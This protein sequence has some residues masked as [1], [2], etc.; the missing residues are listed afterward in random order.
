M[1]S[2]IEIAQE[3]KLIRIDDLA[4]SASLSDDEFEPYG[5]DKAKVCLH[6]DR[7]PHGKLILVTATSGMPAGSG[8]T[9]TSI[10]L[11]QG[12]KR[13][14]EKAVV[15]LREPSLGPCFGMKGGAAGGGYSQVL[16]MESINLHFTGD[17]HAITATNNLLA[18]MI[19]N[20]RHQRQVDLK[21]VIW[22]RVLDVNDRMLRNIITGLGGPANGIPT[23]TGFDITVASELMAVLCLANDLDDLRARIDRLVIGIKRDGSAYT[24]KELGATGALMALLLE[25]MKPNLVQTIE[26]NLAFVHGGPFANIAH[27]CNSVVA[28]KAALTLGD[29][30]ITEAGFGSDLGAEKFINIKCRAAG[31]NPSVIVLVTST[32]ALKWHGL[33]PLADIGKPNPEALR[34]GL[35]NL[36]AHIENLKHFGPEIV[37]SL[38][39]FA[40]DTDEE[41]EIIRNRCAEK[42]VRFA[43]CDGFSK[44]GE[45]AVELAR[46]VM[47]AAAGETKPLHYSYEPDD[48]VLTKLE[49]LAVNVYGAKDIE[50]SSAAKKDWK[51]IQELGFDRLPVCVA[52]TPYSLS[53]EPT[54][55]GAPKGFTLPVERLIL[56]AGAGFV[57]AT[58]GAIMRMPGLPKQPAALRI[59]VVN[60]KIV[61]LS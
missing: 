50:L 60:G 8:K 31:L 28:T 26:G 23:E 19:D 20:A 38:N 9:T 10:A 18:A 41:I 37:V 40:T 13:L 5:R 21:T 11:T 55:L 35:C 29:W 39:H 4:H 42:G 32:K 3:A 34:K 24:C 52:K 15:A 56:N 12:L 14:G 36:D 53:H 44:G 48:D 61:G 27:G 57:V 59:D 16:P 58:T 51:Q 1:K 22:R 17:F 7:K 6:K 46:A 45:G 49:K 33:V 54:W 25:A 2:D 43:V 47:Q 30:A